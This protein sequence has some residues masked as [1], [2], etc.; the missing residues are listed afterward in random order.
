MNQITIGRNSQSTIVVPTQ[1]S[2][3]SGNHATITKEGNSYVLEDHSTNG[4]YINGTYIHNSSCQIRP[5]DRISLGTQYILDFSVVQN[6]FGSGR[7]TQRFA[8]TPATARVTP[9]QAHQQAQLNQ[10]ININVAAQAQENHRETPQCLNRWNWGAFCFGWIWGIGNGVYWPLITLIPYVGQVA[11]LIIVFI[12]GANGS[13]YA[14]EK[15]TGSAAD[16]DAKQHS[17]AVAGGIYILIVVIVSFV[18]GIA[19]ALGA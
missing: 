16:F 7:S 1:Y 15:Y 3:V 17:W 11:A 10:Q 14:W 4:T 12:L 6:L 18:A 9:M 19:I 13:R 5:N 8:G 2:T